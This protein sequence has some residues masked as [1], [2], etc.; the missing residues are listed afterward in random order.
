L[1]ILLLDIE[2]APNVA[3]VW[4]LFNQNIGINQLLESGHVLCWAAK[5]LGEEVCYFDSI[6]RSTRKQM[7]KNIYAM[8]D[9]ADAVVSYNGKRFDIPTLNKEFL[10]A[11]MTPP[12]PYKQIDLLT[13]VRTQFR[14][15]SN[16]LAYVAKRLGIGDKTAHQGHDLWLKCMVGDATAWATMEE[17]NI[18]DVYLLE[19]LYYKV[20][21]WIRNHPNVSVYTGEFVCPKCGSVHYQR[22]GYY[23][24]RSQTYARVQ[25]KSCGGWDRMVIAEKMD[26][27]KKRESI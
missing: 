17:Y 9:E 22:R 23:I 21:P 26:R 8:L 15:P 5:W 24:T 20:L 7:L 4:G 16:K 19:D 18:N 12:A 27:S 25:C 2:T 14:F 6:H 1:K 10:L 13:T 11:K 3:T